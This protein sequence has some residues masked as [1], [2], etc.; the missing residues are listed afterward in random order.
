MDYAEMVITT[1]LPSFC[2]SKINYR[3]MAHTEIQ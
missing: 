2:N 1:K 3:T